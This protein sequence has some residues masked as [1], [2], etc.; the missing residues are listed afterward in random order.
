MSPGPI[1]PVSHP[2]LVLGRIGGQ[3]DLRQLPV[4]NCQYAQ[5][6]STTMITYRVSPIL[7]SLKMNHAVDASKRRAATLVTMGIEFLLGEDITAC[8]SPSYISQEPCPRRQPFLRPRLKIPSSKSGF[9]RTSHWKDTILRASN[10]TT[11]NRPRQTQSPICKCESSRH[12]GRFLQ[13]RQ[14]RRAEGEGYGV[15]KRLAWGL[16]KCAGRKSEGGKMCGRPQQS[17][18]LQSQVLRTVCP[19]TGGDVCVWWCL[20]ELCRVSNVKSSFFGSFS[21][22]FFFFSSRVRKLEWRVRGR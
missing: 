17:Y 11:R 3:F 6:Q 15:K 2:P 9:L 20:H 8:L 4:Q 5:T 22:S 19:R 7:S 12:A 18:P 14:L 21:F 10:R 16:E 13:A 1:A